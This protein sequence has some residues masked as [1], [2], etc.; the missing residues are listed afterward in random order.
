[1]TALLAGL[2]LKM[3]QNVDRNEKTLFDTHVRHVNLIEY[4]IEMHHSRGSMR[5]LDVGNRKEEGERG[6]GRVSGRT[7]QL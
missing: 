1:M 2:I 4:R 5:K 7:N 3:M 6:R